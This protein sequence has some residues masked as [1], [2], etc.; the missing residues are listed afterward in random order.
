MV[1]GFVGDGQG[2]KGC[3]EMVKISNYFNCL[4]AYFQFSSSFCSHT[5]EEFYRTWGTVLFKV[6]LNK[7][8]QF[9]TPSCE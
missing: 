4:V 2:S 6:S 9:S 7:F 5:F 1:V 3:V 8:F